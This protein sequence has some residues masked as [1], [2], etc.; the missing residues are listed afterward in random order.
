MAISQ[1]RTGPQATG[2]PP[3]PA[4]PPAVDGVEVLAL[5]AVLGVGLLAWAG[6]V[7][8]D[9]GRYRL[10]GAVGL[11]G[12]AAAAIGLVAWRSRP[13]PRLGAD[14]PSLAVLLGVGLVAAFLFFPGFSYGVGK[15]PGAYV[16]H[17]MAIARTG[18]SGLDDP[19]IVRSRVPAVEVMREDPE[20][21]FPG[22]WI[23]DRDA[24]RSI[25]QFY[26]L[27]PALLASGFQAGGYTGLAN[28]TPVC[29]LLA[30]LLVVL[31]ARRAFGLVAG[32]VAGLL[33]AANMLEVWHAKYP[34][35]EVFTQ[36]LIG[37]ALLGVVL[38][39]KTGWRPAAGA[40]GLLLGLVYLA[41]ADALLLLLLACGVGCALLVT[42]RF[43]AR[44]GWF[45]A[46]LAVALPYGLLQAYVLA[47]RYT[48]ANLV[49]DFPVVLAAIVGALALAVL[50]GRV[51]PG[52]GRWGVRQLERRRTQLVLGA[53]LVA[54]AALLLA[55]GFLR[56]WLFEPVYIVIN[57]RRARSYD[58]ASLI[59]LSWFLTVPA[60]GLALGGLALV[61][62]RRW[63]AAAWTLVLPA[64]LLLP[65]YA[66]R[67]AVSTRLLWWTR[68]F[69]PVILPGLIVL[70]AVALGAGL[71]LA[72]GSGRWR[73]AVQAGSAL[74][75][76][77]LLAVFLSQSLPLRHHQ[78][79]NGSFETTQRIARA[80]GGRQGV[81]LW[82]QASGGLY[83]ISYLFG[84]PV[85]MQQGQVSALLPRRPSPAYVQS[86][87]RGFPGQPV[88]LVVPG[89]AA[90]RDYAGLGLRAVDRITY[91]MP[92]WEETYVTRPASARGVPLRFSIWQV[93]G[94]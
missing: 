81:F 40:A 93:G 63:R 2:Q 54:A 52:V 10:L 91:V 32:A 72:A 58:E 3:P 30:V 67:A 19:A 87:V 71:T 79:H 59:R 29:G 46:G 62:L 83:E 92:V 23:K 47:R 78:E 39:I 21:R 24:G 75:L 85:W 7:L 69:V 57:G 73:R 84:G 48:L 36:L 70:A 6:L 22:I 8:A 82:Q 41:R 18:S 56:P 80:A 61:A 4:P 76:A 55:L 90:P 68:R 51:A 43:D 31:A 5:A 17:G 28:V 16:S 35:S 20:A 27:W 77:S 45:A 64:L 88:F 11:A 94:A 65:L 44:A 60:F 13:R 26:H 15:D 1:R 89:S 14:G 37:G 50:L 33:L 49:P 9:A 66:Y 86:F 53:T 25:V 74:A 38:A 12:L 42:G 34:S